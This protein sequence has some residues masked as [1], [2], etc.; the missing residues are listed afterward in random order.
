MVFLVPFLFS[1]AVCHE[2]VDRCATLEHAHT[3]FG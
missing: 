2:L 3:V 1:T